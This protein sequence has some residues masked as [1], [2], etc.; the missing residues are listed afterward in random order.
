M[1]SIPQKSMKTMSAKV[2]AVVA[3][4]DDVEFMLA[5]TLLLFKQAGA[6]IHIWNLANGNLGTVRHDR[7]QIAAIRW[8]EA[9]DSARLAGATL[10]PPL[11][12]DLGI[13]YDARSLARVAAGIRLIQPTIVF[14]HPTSDYMEDHQN[15]A[16]LAI[17]AVFSR[18]MTNYVTEPCRPPFD[19]PVAIYHGLP[20]GLRGP[21][22]E[23]P[24]LSHVVRIDKVSASKRQMLAQHRSQKEWLDVSQGM[25][26]Y[27]NEMERHDRE[28]GRMSGCFQMAEGFMQHSHVGFSPAGWDP[29][30]ALLGDNVRCLSTEQPPNT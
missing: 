3:H 30:T 9:M 20:H 26:A 15:T 29:L 21:L 17:T 1:E 25:D 16:R 18:A 4:P 24:T 2:L 14:T 22:G 12:D 13:F 27:L 19:H 23:R 6:E 28:V 10:H 5:G 8:N 7:E 11:F